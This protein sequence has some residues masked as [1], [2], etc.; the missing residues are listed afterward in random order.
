MEPSLEQTPLVNE[1]LDNVECCW[2]QVPDE[3]LLELVQ[4]SESRDAMTQLVERH[5]SLV[6]SV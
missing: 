2:A 1:P 5:A 4:R 3:E 6:A